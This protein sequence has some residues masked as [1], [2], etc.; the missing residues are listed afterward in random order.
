MISW[1]DKLNGWVGRSVSWLNTI[2]VLIVC[3]DVLLRRYLNLTQV[4]VGELE[5][6]LFALIFLFGAG[7]TL[8]KNKHVRVDLFYENFP[9]REKAW[10]NLVG[11]FV[12]LIPWCILLIYYSIYFGYDAWLLKE[13]SPDPGG[14]PARYLIKFAIPLGL[15]LLALQG[16]SEGLK[17]LNVLQNTPRS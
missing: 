7:F 8:L 15:F 6:H 3:I 16:L 1:I 11:N 17:A 5:W 14:L 4:W 12:F 10:V 9:E 2:L 13:T